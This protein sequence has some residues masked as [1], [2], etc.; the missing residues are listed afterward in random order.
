VVERDRHQ[1]HLISVPRLAPRE[2][3]FVAM[4]LA[5]FMVSVEATIVATAMPTIVADLGGLR[6]FSWVFGAYLLTQAV[7]I[8][9]Y[10][11]LADF[12]GRKK[13]LMIAIVVFLAGSILSG[14]AHSMFQLILFRGLQG[15]GGGGVQPVAIT[16]V[17]DMYSGRERARV[18]GVMSSTW[19]FSAVIGPLLGAFLIGHVG[20]QSIFWINVPVGIGCIAIM[21]RAFDE[22]IARVAH[23]IDYAGS[24]LLAAGVGTL[25]YVL[26]MLGNMP[27]LPAALLGATAV[28]ILA[29]LL[30]HELRTAEPMM[31][32]FL[33]KIR[34]IAISNTGNFALGAMMMGISAFMPTF[35]QGAMGKS[36]VTAGAVLGSIFIGWTCGSIGGAR[37]MLRTSYRFTAL[38]GCGP[39][40]A[41][42][43]LLAAL[44]ASSPIAQAFAGVTLLGLGFGLINSVFVISTQAAVGWDLRG[45]ATSSNIFLRQIGQA[46]GSATF[47]AVFNI[48]IY[49]R[50]PDA[51][52]AVGRLMD[53]RARALIPPLDLARAANAVALSLHGVYLILTA[54]ALVEFG[55]ILALPPKLRPEHAA[56]SA[57]PAPAHGARSA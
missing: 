33:Y 50:I 41:G 23:R 25:M 38:T 56:P 22:Q 27:P 34:M 42:S 48:G 39:M 19:A 36:A 9:I 46:I 43:L 40:I 3:I 31:P 45:A 16:I 17:G 49:T 51:G 35:V 11:R 52:A 55:I 26:V 28:A 53:A 57:A 6:Y 14:F 10:G 8:P 15:I 54:L 47:G 24:V 2:V 37:L 5:I 13:L 44:T 18:Q 12:F 7:C 29:I 32:L 20:W 21:V 30:V 4:I 1:R